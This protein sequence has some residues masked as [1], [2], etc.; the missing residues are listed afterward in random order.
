MQGV[1]KEKLGVVSKQ[2]SCSIV[3][4]D[5][6]N[7]KEYKAIEIFLLNES[8]NIYNFDFKGLQ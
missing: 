5:S 3:F 4:T 7:K 8:Y 1:A 6:F 2:V